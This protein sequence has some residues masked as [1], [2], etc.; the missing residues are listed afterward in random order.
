[1][2][3][4]RL[5]GDAAVTAG[6]PPRWPCWWGL[7]VT[8]GLVQACHT[9]Q[10]PLAAELGDPEQ[11][12]LLLEQYDCGRCHVIPGVRR[13]QGLHGPTLAAY[14]RRAYIAGELPNQP[15]R[16][17]HWI[18]DPGELVPGTLMPDMGVSDPHAR[19]MGAYLMR[20]R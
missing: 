7:L 14:A 8:A 12:R 5:P 15:R 16:L 1:M 3:H 13:A 2:G 9:R 20:L 10:P 17:V 19:D 11:G 4:A 18:T 6:P